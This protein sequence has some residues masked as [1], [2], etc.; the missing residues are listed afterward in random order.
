MVTFYRRHLPHWQPPGQDLFITW[1]LFGSLPAKFRPPKA[2]ET[3]GKQFVC[4]D[5]ELDQARIGPIWLSEPKVAAVAFRELRAADQQKN[6]FRLRA[7]VLM[8][9]HILILIE[10]FA[11]LSKITHQIKGAT[12]YRA[13]L[14]LSRTYQRFWQDESFDRWVRTPAEGE[15]IRKYIENNPVAAG[16]VTRPEDWPWSSASRPIE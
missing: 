5:R 11:P 9:N 8:A 15:K 16:L 7:Y 3:D 1:R 6:L 14:I 2:T 4:F 12:A 10:P 13:N